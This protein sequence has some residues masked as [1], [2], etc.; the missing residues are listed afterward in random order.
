M[1]KH[2]FGA[3]TSVLALGS[4]GTAS[5]TDW[6]FFDE[7]YVRLSFGKTD[8]GRPSDTEGHDDF[9]EFTLVPFADSNLRITN[10][11]LGNEDDFYLSYAAGFTGTLDNGVQLLGKVQVDTGANINTFWEDFEVYDWTEENNLRELWFGASNFGQGAFSEATV[12]AGRRFYR[13]KDVHMT[14]YYY[15]DY[16]PSGFGAGFG[17]EN[18][19]LGFG[20]LSL[21][22]MDVKKPAFSNDPDATRDFGIN[23]Y[24][25]RLHDIPIYGN[26]SGE[27]GVAYANGFGPGFQ[28][29]DNGGRA[30]D[31][32]A[33]RA[34]VRNNNFYG[35]FITAALM[36]GE[37]AAFSLDP[38]GTAFAGRED[39]RTRFVLHGV[40]GKS[41]RLQ[42]MFTA[43]S[44]LI[45]YD[46]GFNERYESVGWRTQYQFNENWALQGEVGFDRWENDN[47]DANIL[48]KITIAPTYTFGRE[49][50]FSR[51]QLRAFV[52]YGSWNRPYANAAQSGVGG[53]TA[54]EGTS[55]G[56]SFETWF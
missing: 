38:N 29:A 46:G 55:Y 31:G 16:S 23:T 10:Y 47:T 21:A 35:G 25:V 36:H 42:H 43:V 53:V 40:V 32:I 13:R 4:A 18:I 1:K 11:R 19:S 33:Y 3:L 44:E 20:N 22:Y 26:W 51:P 37:G 9:R 54:T 49:G 30:E 48:R 50:I 28:T 24:D 14:D 15:E 56:V 8:V 45:E 12:W 34:H 7:G 52:T 6:K 39:Q 5:A 17:I 41:K 2:M 27:V